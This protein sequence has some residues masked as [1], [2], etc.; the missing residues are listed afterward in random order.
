MNIPT[1]MG[2]SSSRRRQAE[3]AASCQVHTWPPEGR[4]EYMFVG[5]GIGEW[6]LGDDLEGLFSVLPCTSYV[7]PGIIIIISAMLC[8]K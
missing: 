8:C 7:R 5:T 4:G 6:C 2:G 3:S 1:Y